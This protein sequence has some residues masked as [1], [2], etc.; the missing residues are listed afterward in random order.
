MTCHCLQE[1][2]QS[3]LAKT[4]ELTSQASPDLSQR[5]I[6][7]ILPLAQHANGDVHKSLWAALASQKDCLEP[8][9]LKTVAEAS[10]NFI[11][12]LDKVGASSTN[13]IV[14]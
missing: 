6:K 13:E 3:L 8:A 11:V 7:A 5:F 2:C 14:L 10:G 4:G 12:Q 9:Q 1:L